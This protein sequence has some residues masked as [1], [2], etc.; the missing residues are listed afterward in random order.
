MYSLSSLESL[1][2]S[3][4]DPEVIGF[5]SL[6]SNLFPS[7]TVHFF[8]FFDFYNFLQCWNAAILFKNITF[9]SKSLASESKEDS[10]LERI[11]ADIDLLSKTPGT[12]STKKSKGSKSSKSQKSDKSSKKS[13]K[14]QKSEKSDKDED[15]AKEFIVSEFEFWAIIF[16]FFL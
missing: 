1:T 10:E 8:F 6:L 7:P 2:I 3:L 4:S 14:S 12:A 5:A 11:V 13:G 16:F 9:S 15:K